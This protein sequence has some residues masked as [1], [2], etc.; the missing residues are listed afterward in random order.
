MMNEL[1]KLSKTSFQIT[2]LDIG[3]RW[4]FNTDLLSIA[5]VVNAVGFEPD[6]KECELLN[7]SIKDSPWKSIK[8]LP[9]ALG[10]KKEA[11]LNLYKQRG[12]SSLLEAD[13]EFADIF[14]RGDYY[15]P[16]GKENI[17]TISLDEAAGIYGFKNASYMKIDIQGAEMDVFLSGEK[18]LSE[19]IL[20]I[21]LEAS[22]A[23]QYKN[24][25]LFSDL[26]IFLQKRGYNLMQFIEQHHWRRTSKVKYP[27]PSKG[28]YPFSLGQLIHGDAL[29]LK[30]PESM[31]NEAE[32]DRE[33]LLKL[34]LISLAYGYIDHAEAALS[35]SG[36][37]EYI[38]KSFNINTDDLL[39][40]FSKN[41]KRK[42]RI[43]LLTNI[44][45]DIRNFIK[46]YNIKC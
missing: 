46:S 29:Y 43:D 17:S 8:Y 15:I 16:D 18:L 11:V 39:K 23:P 40:E 6:K 24:Q 10:T 33:K 34:A 38:K 25:P 4:G 42:T 30:S 32:T 21:R 28:K 5:Q 7:K 3:A 31:S 9:I 22:F 13:K 27:L 12:C 19:S 45:K 26:D 20:G 2:C 1:K 44:K 14:S 41:F 37:R 35:R 36:M